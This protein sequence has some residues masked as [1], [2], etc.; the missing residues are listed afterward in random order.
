MSSSATPRHDLWIFAFLALVCTA[1]FFSYRLGLPGDFVFDDH[2]NLQELSAHGGVQDLDRLK[3]YLDESFA[4]PTGRPVSMLTFL[5]DA[6]QWPADP[7]RLKYKNILLHILNGLLLFA[8]LKLALEQARLGWSRLEILWGSALTAALWLAHPLQV[9]T[10]LYVIQRMAELSTLFVFLGL[11]GYLAGRRLLATEPRRGYALMSLSVIVCTALATFSKENGALL[12]VLVLALEYTLLS[13][14][15]SR[16]AWKWR[17]VF[18]W[19]PGIAIAGYLIRTGLQD[20]THVLAMRGFTPVERLLTETRILVDYLYQWFVPH[21]TTLGLFRDDVQPS[22]SLTAPI[23]TAYASAF[24]L[25]LLAAAASLRKRAPLFSAAVLFFFTGH[26]IESTVVPLELYFE[27]RNYLPAALLFLPVAGGL[28]RLHARH[29]QWARLATTTAVLGLLGML[30][31]RAEAWGD[32]TRLYLHW[33]ERNPGSARAQLAASNVLQKT[34]NSAAAT[35]L[36]QRAAQR[37][38]ESLTIRLQLLRLLARNARHID[39]ALLDQVI[40]NARRGR[41]HS[42]S[43]LAAQRL[44]TDVLSGGTRTIQPQWL[45]QLW[46]AMAENPNNRVTGTFT[47]RIEHETGRVYAYLE[48]TERALEHFD[49]SLDKSPRV[50]AAIMQAAVLATYEQYCPALE[51]LQRAESLLDTDREAALRRPYYLKEIQRLNE[52]M[53]LDAARAGQQCAGGHA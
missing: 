24:I 29:P 19:L 6:R 13:R 49:L 32:R 27:H 5:I 16:P 41:L 8:W 12:P 21:P 10:V 18:L 43:I 40:H 50:E 46:Q 9:S 17:A 48:E 31:F 23:T 45:I 14:S 4:G 3:R 39:P 47:A 25:A 52:I 44:T 30:A 28:V 38:P 42:E 37:H 15:A 7:G 1:V 33:A 26:L 36:L 11:L 20:P 2:P 51:R 35:E 22:H 53:G 34:V